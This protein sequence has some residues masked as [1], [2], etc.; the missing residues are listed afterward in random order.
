MA[1]AA[2]RDDA[3][4]PLRLRAVLFDAVGTLIEL[5]EPVGE[6]YARL[7]LAY[8]VRLPADPIEAAWRRAIARSE[9]RVF[10]GATSDQ[11]TTLERQWWFR[12]VAATFL[13]L[14]IVQL[15]SGAMNLPPRGAVFLSE[16][17][18]ATDYRLWGGDVTSTTY[19]ALQ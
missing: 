12:V 2:S 10:P 5:V 13:T 19:N 18:I 3:V 11:A 17:S 16:L 6:S 14:A 9:P 8:G 1:R 4:S 7:A 15:F